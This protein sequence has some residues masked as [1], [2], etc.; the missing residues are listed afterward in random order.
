MNNDN[1]HLISKVEQFVKETLKEDV[2]GHDYYHAFRVR[3]V[4]MTIAKTEPG[5]LRVIELAALLHDIS[6]FKFNGGDDTKGGRIAEKFLNGIGE[7]ESVISQV[8]DVINSVSF[9]GANVE[10][11][12]LT[13]EAKIVQ[14]ADRLDALGAIGIGRCFSYGGYKGH[15]MH[16]PEV[17][18]VMHTSFEQYKNHKGTS[19]NHFY[20]KL[21]LLKDRMNTKTGGALAEHRHA[22]MEQF[23]NTFL[24]EWNGK[25]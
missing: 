10:I 12:H 19:L 11:K 4:A 21:F 23:V 18:V 7:Q 24:L 8:V 16:D 13:N 6:D 20:E 9:K 2:T 15:P 3:D 25:C 17:P 5:E 22:F 1:R 14:D